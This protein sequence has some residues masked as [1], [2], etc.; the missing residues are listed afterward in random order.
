MIKYKN[1]IYGTVRECVDEL[2]KLIDFNHA[3]FPN[4]DFATPYEGLTLEDFKDSDSPLDFG[5]SWHGCKDLGLEFD[6]DT[7]SLL[8]GHYGG[9]GIQSLELFGD[10]EVKEKKWFMRCIASSV[11]EIGYSRMLPDDYILIEVKRKRRKN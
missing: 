6:A 10:D 2:W 4:F 9:G 8:F 11:E 1:L 7:I 3:I 5:E